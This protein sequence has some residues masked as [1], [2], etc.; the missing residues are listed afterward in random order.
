MNIIRDL[1]GGKDND[2]AFFS[3]MRG[4]GSWADLIRARMRI[5]KSRNGLGSSKWSVRSDLFVPPNVN[6]QLNLF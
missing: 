6:G 2:P 3:R 1:R 5:A 4:S